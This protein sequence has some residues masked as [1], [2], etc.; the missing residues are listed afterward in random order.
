MWSAVNGHFLAII[1]QQATH[2]NSQTTKARAEGSFI[3]LG[4]VPTKP[5]HIGPSSTWMG[6]FYLAEDTL[7]VNSSPQTSNQRKSGSYQSDKQAFSP[8]M[9]VLL[10]QTPDLHEI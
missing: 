2:E 6:A 5:T 3:I 7:K 4:Y 1:N 10:E 9:L 8:Q